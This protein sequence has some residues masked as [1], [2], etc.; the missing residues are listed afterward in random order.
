MFLMNKKL[1]LLLA[2][3]FVGLMSS[4]LGDDSSTQGYV[5]PKNNQIGSFS[6][7]NDSIPELKNTK[8]YIDQIN[9]Q[10]FNLDSLPYGSK[11]TK[12]ICTL[13]YVNASAVS[14]LKV[15]QEA[16][17]DT[18]E[19]NTTDSLDFSKPVK[20]IVTAYDGV[21]TK[22]YNAFVNIHTIMPDTLEWNLY[23]TEVTGQI[24]RDQKVINANYQGREVYFLYGQ[25]AG[26]SLPYR[27]Y[28]SGVDDMRS[29]TEIPLN[30]FSP[31]EIRLSQMTRF[32]NY[33]FVPS[34]SGSLYR[35][36]DGIN[37]TAMED[38]PK[39]AYIL[40]LVKAGGNQP[41]VLATIV[42]QDGQLL[43]ASLDEGGVW[44]TGETVPEEFPLTGFGNENFT[45]MFNT[46]LMVVG[47]RTANNRLVNS[48]W[49][50]IDGTGWAL[51]T[52]EEANYFENREGSMVTAYDDKI[53]MIGGF[54]AAGKAYKDIY[55]TIDRGVTWFPVD[56]MI[57]LPPT[58]RERGF[59]S[60]IVDKDQFI[61][62]F[63]GQMSPNGNV[64]QEIWRG[65]IN[66]LGFKD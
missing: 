7:T 28:Y 53:Y 19:W 64:L 63:G 27:L 54:D 14:Q 4:C 24:M 62:I 30:G 5:M 59:G 29:W 31:D 46:Y 58:Y 57:I 48:S 21:T 23:A 8:F 34:I 42:E 43:F 1:A 40:G 66:R 65:R 38:I 35:S 3:S 60:I 2:V 50:T 26:I 56:S 10:I 47:G 33:Y 36:S 45:S 39:V 22:S 13:E 52:D 25:P 16:V 55:E 51:L 9:G 61:T 6:L 44:V 11:L 12:A 37:W 18:I 17:G 20:F 32:N 15:V 49:G 41:S